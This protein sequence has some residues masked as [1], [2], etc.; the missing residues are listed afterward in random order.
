[1]NNALV[2]VIYSS[3]VFIP[4]LIGSI[5][6]DSYPRISKLLRI[7]G[8]TAPP[9]LF[10]LT[11]YIRLLDY[12]LVLTLVTVIAALGIS[13]H[14]EAYYRVLYGTSR[15]FQISIDVILASLLL[16]YSSTYFIELIIYWFIL[17][18]L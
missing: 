6:V 7:M 13:L 14:S 16:L 5:M 18:I 3:S 9:L 4:I 2:K 15:F 11:G 8:F 17:D 12:Q 10:I 1:M